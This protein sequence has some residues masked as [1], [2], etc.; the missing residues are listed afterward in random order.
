M[1][2]LR[3]FQKISTILLLISLIILPVFFLPITQEFFD[4]NKW[5]LFVGISLFIMLLW[6][7]RLLFTGNTGI[8]WS[9]T[10]L[11]LGLL[12]AASFVTLTIASFNKID[13]LLSPL[14]PITFL[15]STLILFFGASLLSQKEKI[16]LRLGLT[17][18]AGIA[19]L[20]AL[21]QHIGLGTLF[22]PTG[23]SFADPFFT[24]V[25][26]TVSLLTYLT[27]ML[28]VSISVALHALK[29]KKE[30]IAALS[31]VTT[32]LIVCGMG[33]TLW[34][35]AP[36][37]SSRILPLSL[38]VAILRS[39]WNTLPHI[40][41][42]VGS[43]KFFEVFTLH[44]PQSVN[45]TPLWNTGFTAN[46]SL[47]LHIGS[48]L[49]IFG[50]ICLIVFC[51]ELVKEWG[52]HPVTK[53]QAGLFIL[54]SFFAPPTFILIIIPVLFI[55][56]SDTHNTIGG[57]IQ[58]FGR[59]LI[60]FFVFLITMLSFYGLFRWYSGERLLYQAFIAS[61]SGN[62]SKTFILEEKAIK[63]NPMNASFRR[64][65]SQTCL[66]LAKSIISA[67]PQN[68][69][70]TP[71]LSDDEK[72]LLTNLVSRG[73]QEA[74]LAVILSP[75]NVNAWVNL[76]QIYQGLTGI[77][78]ESD[79]WA[80]AAFQKAMSLDPTNPV[81]H[82]NLGGLY[83]SL[84]RWEEA[85]K[86]FLLSIALK[87]NY[88]DGFYNLANAFRQKNDFDNA[89]KALEQT[90]L[91]VARGSTDEQKI[92][93]EIIILRQEREQKGQTRQPTSLFVPQLKLPNR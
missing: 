86:E 49:G 5:M 18:G 63:T 43:E 47:A 82:L 74:K 38:G 77:A 72:T 92:Q 67:A 4:T 26:S 28:P 68:E 41:F 54:L 51:I 85:G 31:V 89:V 88:I 50:L 55:L 52:D 19:G 25:G 56:S 91:L 6:T 24:P 3:F 10:T 90:N 16:I 84:G 46:A 73:I 8:S 2:I 9:G 83:M 29:E 64:A 27:L 36:L 34:T 20:A 58:G 60:A 17:V 53:I 44:R 69:Q 70:G 62:G 66:M 80:A 78:K 23:T 71:D 61:Q 75:T 21:Y 87:P 22:F 39:S 57:K 48:T 11:G 45:M 12:A 30:T 79:T 33:I 81:L 32:L 14:G 1:N 15:S 65:I 93:Q 37:S 42:G 76:A 13:A 35:Y 59:F 7:G 40:L